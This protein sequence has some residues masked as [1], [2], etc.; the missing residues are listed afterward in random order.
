MEM[1]RKTYDKW[2]DNEVVVFFVESVMS[3]SKLSHNV[4]TTIETVTE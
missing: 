2:T 4:Y 3:G 1:D